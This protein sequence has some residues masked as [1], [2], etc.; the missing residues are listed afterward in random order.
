V[1]FFSWTEWDLRRGSGDRRDERRGGRGRDDDV[2][3]R[4]ERLDACHV[5]TRTDKIMML[6][7][8]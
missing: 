2:A 7:G 3:R 8:V 5:A 1:L 4:R 6:M